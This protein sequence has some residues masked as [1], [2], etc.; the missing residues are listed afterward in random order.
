[1]IP[2]IMREE[3]IDE[4]EK[5]KILLAANFRRSKNDIY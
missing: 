5:L 3:L 4:D 2:A 1:M